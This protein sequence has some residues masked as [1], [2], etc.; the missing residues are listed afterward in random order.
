MTGNSLFDPEL[1]VLHGLRLIGFAETRAIADVTGLDGDLVEDRLRRSEA[2]GH[3]AFRRGHRQGWV[4]TPEGRAAGADLLAR[5]LVASQ[6]RD[7]VERAYSR[8][9]ALN[10]AMLS[11]C[12]RW[13]VRQQDP[14]I[15]ND[16]QDPAYDEAVV[17]D[18]EEIDGAVQPICAQLLSV[19]PRFQRYGPG[20]ANA[21]MRLKSGDREWL[22]KP[23]IMS[24]HTLWFELHEDLLATLGLD[25]ASETAK[26]SSQNPSV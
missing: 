4:L 3:V 2:G 6:A 14:L 1:L 24:Y 23:T 17:A 20:F 19:L 10:Q 7:T 12:T 13:Q 11:V 21:L 9:V 25:R 18:L 8:F 15:L 16:H 22:T 5:E 26:F